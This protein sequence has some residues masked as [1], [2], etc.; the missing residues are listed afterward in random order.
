MSRGGQ[1]L[2]VLVRGPPTAGE[3]KALERAGLQEETSHSEGRLF[4]L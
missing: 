4:L 1:G 3:E 2:N